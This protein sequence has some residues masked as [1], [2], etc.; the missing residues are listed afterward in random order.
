MESEWVIY[1]LTMPVIPS[2]SD[3]LQGSEL[4]S[5]YLDKSRKELIL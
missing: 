5:E 3:Q 4:L 1:S 2:F